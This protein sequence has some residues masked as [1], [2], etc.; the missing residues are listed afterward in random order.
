DPTVSQQYAFLKHISAGLRLAGHPE[1][2]P[3]QTPAVPLHE[4]AKRL[5]VALPGASQDGWG[6]RGVHPTPLDGFRR[7]WLGSGDTRYRGG[8]ASTNARPRQGPRSGLQ[9]SVAGDAGR[10]SGTRSPP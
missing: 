6:L 8:L 1:G 5:A 2:E 3:E 9:S 10:G 7:F 4:R